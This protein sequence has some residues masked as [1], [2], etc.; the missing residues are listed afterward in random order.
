MSVESSFF[1]DRPATEEELDSL[2]DDTPD[3]TGT[4]KYEDLH[5]V[6][7]TETYHRVTAE[8]TVR[9]NS[10]LENWFFRVN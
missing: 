4:A 1:K 2:P 10:F 6:T 3:V 7:V 5:K 8:G 9:E